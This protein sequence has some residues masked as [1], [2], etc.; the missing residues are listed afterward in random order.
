MLSIPKTVALLAT[1]IFSVCALAQPRATNGMLDARQHNFL[2][3]PIKLDGE[4]RFAESELIGADRQIKTE[5][6]HVFTEP[7]KE[8]HGFA[9]Y[10]LQIVLGVPIPELAVEIPQ[11]YSSYTLW[12]NGQEVARNGIVGT[13]HNTTTPQWLPQTKTFSVVGDTLLLTLQMANFHH[14]IGGAKNPIYLGLP[15]QLLA[16][17]KLSHLLNIILLGSLGFIGLV[18]LLTY[19]FVKREKSVL[20]FALLCLIWSLRSIFSEQYLAIYWMPNF[21]W[22]LGLKIE[23][24]TL[25]LTMAWAMLFVS[26]LYPQDV[27]KWVKGLLLYPNFLFVFLTMATPAQLYTELLTIYLFLQGLLLIYILV[28]VFRAIVYDRYGAWFSVLGICSLSAA[29]GYNYLSY[30]GLFEFYPVALYS[31]YLIFFVLLAVALGYQLSPKASA[32][33]VSESLSLD[34]FR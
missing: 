14:A 1:T 23:Y 20:Y 7:W 34:D 11:L 27:N 9:T 13:T 10:Q 3:Q 6:Y 25:Y 2:T 24:I 26:Y 19:F 15:E 30:Q 17:Q 22:E 16:E 28:V 31:C 33:N 18:F 8:S 21:D 29:F 32:R 4:W 5:R 12:I